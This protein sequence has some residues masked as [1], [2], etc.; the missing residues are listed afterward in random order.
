MC[1][2]EGSVIIK[3][4]FI[5]NL[6]FTSSKQINHN[7]HYLNISHSLAIVLS[8]HFNNNFNLFLFYADATL[9]YKCLFTNLIDYLY[10]IL[11]NYCQTK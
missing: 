11:P 5:Q 8:F 6:R 3:K 1:N 7:K 10:K 9:F 2:E 4:T